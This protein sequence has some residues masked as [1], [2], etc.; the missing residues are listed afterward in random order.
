[1]T[2]SIKFNGKE[3]QNSVAR[4]LVA[5]VIISGGILIAVFGFVIIPIILALIALV[6]VLTVPLHF[7][8]RLCGDA[9]SWFGKATAIPGPAT[10]PFS[11]ANPPH[12]RNETK[13]SFPAKGRFSF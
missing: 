7:T 13:P 6:F 5:L 11:D 8:L 3:V 9:V 10:A 4:I 1:V 2:T 12:W